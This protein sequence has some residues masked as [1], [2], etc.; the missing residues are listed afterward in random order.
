MESLPNEILLHLFNIA[1]RYYPRSLP[2]ISASCSR[3]HALAGCT[4]VARCGESRKCARVLRKVRGFI[5]LYRDSSLLAFTANMQLGYIMITIGTGMTKN[6]KYMAPIDISANLDT[7]T[8]CVS[9]R[10]DEN[11]NTVKKLRQ[12]LASRT[13]LYHPVCRVV[14]LLTNL[15]YG[16]FR[17]AAA[18][19]PPIILAKNTEPVGAKSGQSAVDARRKRAPGKWNDAEDTRAHRTARSDIGGGRRQYPV[20]GAGLW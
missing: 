15:Y 19:I 4:N 6:K 2:A 18:Q 16:A 17:G 12:V 10:A 13:P 7:C 5:E 1:T 11:F 9:C 3:H 8:Y 20:A 14:K